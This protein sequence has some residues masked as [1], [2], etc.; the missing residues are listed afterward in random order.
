MTFFLPF[1]L[2]ALFAHA[3]EDDASDPSSPSHTSCS[4]YEYLEERWQCN[5]THHSYPLNYGLKYCQLFLKL[6]NKANLALKEFLHDTTYCLQRAL[7][8]FDLCNEPEQSRC[9]ELERFAFGSH[10]SCYVEN[11]F[12]GLSFSDQAHVAKRLMNLDVLLK[13][14]L[15][16]AQSMKIGLACAV[17]KVKG[18]HCIVQ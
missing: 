11:D 10:T 12:Q 17:T 18:H 3:Y 4:Y 16:F 5:N 8:Q 13:P 9:N 6:G 15:S 7:E 2:F 14:R 1:F